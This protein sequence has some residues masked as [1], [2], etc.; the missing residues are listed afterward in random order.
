M[1]SQ[2]KIK[3]FQHFNLKL[4][5]QNIWKNN[6]HLKVKE[7]NLISGKIFKKEKNINITLQT[8]CLF[9]PS[10]TNIYVEMSKVMVFGGGAFGVIRP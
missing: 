7:G 5:S 10:S 1:I 6:F 4:N 2:P 9:S 8:E 3:R